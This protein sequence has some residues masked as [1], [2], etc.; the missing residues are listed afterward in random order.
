MHE[1]GGN[2]LRCG[3]IS[4]WLKTS[5][6]KKLRAEVDH[7]GAPPYFHVSNPSQLSSL[8]VCHVLI[9]AGLDSMVLLQT[10]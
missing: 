1:S 2:S 8:I 7:F 10:L 4:W 6:D 5:S 3:H 9:D